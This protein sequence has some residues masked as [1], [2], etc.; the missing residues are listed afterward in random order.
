[1]APLTAGRLMVG[2]TAGEVGRSCA[3]LLLLVL[4]LVLP[5]GTVRAQSPAEPLASCEGMAVSE[6]SIEP[7]DPSFLRVP[8]ALRGFARAVGLHHTTSKARVIA[9]FVLLEVGEPCTERGRSETERIL[10]MQPFLA[11]ATVRAFPDTMGG[12]RIEVETIDEIP[13]VLR[14][15]FDGLLPSEVRF[16]NGNVAGRGLHVAADVKRGFAFRTGFGVDA[17]ASQVF[18][19]PYTLSLVAE[20]APLGSALSLELGH[21]F[22]TDLQRTGWH[23]GVSDVNRYLAFVAPDH[24]PI[25][26]SVERRFWD[27][28]GVRRFELGRPSAF[29]GAL[30]SSESVVPAAGALVVTEE[31]LVADTTGML[32]GPFPAYRHL[33]A[34][35]VIGVRALT[36]VPVRGFDALTAVQDVATGA[37]LGAVLG[38]GVGGSGVRSDDRF[39]SADLY[40]GHGS[41]RSFAAIR[42]EGEA[43]WDPAM[44]RWDSMVGGG[45]LAWYVKP[46]DAHLSVVSVEVGGA[47]RTRVP[48]QLQLG[49]PGGGVRGYAASRAAGAVRGVVRVEERWALGAVNRHLAIGLAGFADAGFVRAGQTPGGVDSG[50]RAAVGLGLLAAVPPGSKRLWRLDVALPVSADR[51]ARWEVRLSSASTRSFWQEPGDVARARAGAAPSTI[52]AWP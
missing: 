29:A 25:S 27:V 38:W 19:R 49:A 16:G 41:P 48:A 3:G 42:F 18:G 5:S 22:L 51:H 40:V 7:R 37:Q 43:R 8:P 31:G 21:S 12:V 2:L 45:R 52:F 30:L 14:V 35:A 13:T 20:R 50:V 34:N 24:D 15:G 4:L 1:M 44:R 17:S 28:G 36:F 26:L 11:G 6:I 10:R 9:R 32:G 39:V 33:R 46:A 23:A 47:V